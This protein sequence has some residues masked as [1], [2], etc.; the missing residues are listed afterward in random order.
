MLIA[1]RLQDAPE[2]DGAALR[3]W[4]T[5]NP[6]LEKEFMSGLA[7]WD[8]LG[9][10]A[11][12]PDVIAWRRQALDHL[13]NGRQPSLRSRYWRPIAAVAALFLVMISVAT[14]MAMGVGARDGDTVYATKLGQRGTVHLADGSTVSLDENSEI[15][16]LFSNSTR[17]VSLVRGQA[18][19]NVEHDGRP[20]LVNVMDREVRAVGT[21]FNVDSAGD[22]SVSLLEG[23]ILVSPLEKR[24]SWWGGERRVP[25]RRQSVSLVAGQELIFDPDSPPVIRPFNSEGVVAWEQGRLVFD[26]DTL[27]TAIERVNRYAPTKI[28]LASTDPGSERISGVFDTGDSASF[29]RAVVTLYPHLKVHRDGSGRIIL[30]R[31]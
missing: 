22:L 23:S 11:N 13:E 8:A 4:L 28:E 2:A 31:S 26:A 27:E 19:F 29:I 1:L 7:A 21:N 10:L 5:D 17:L 3:A 30:S 15:N 6:S 14:W 12:E 20:F 25:D 16:V 24:D 18:R 9:E